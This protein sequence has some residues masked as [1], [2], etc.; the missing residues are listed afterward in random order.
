V[1]TPITLQ[2]TAKDLLPAAQKVAD[3]IKTLC[4]ISEV[5][6]AKVTKLGTKGKGVAA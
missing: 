6:D 4:G 3:R 5:A 2:I 1:V